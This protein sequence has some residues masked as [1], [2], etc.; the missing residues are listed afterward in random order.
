[1]KIRTELGIFLVLGFAILVLIPKANCNQFTFYMN[2]GES[3]GYSVERKKDEVVK[4]KFHTFNDP[5]QVR[6]VVSGYSGN[7]NP[8]PPPLLSEEKIFDS[9]SFTALVSS[10]FNFW[11]T[12]S[13]SH[14]GYIYIEITI[15]PLEEILTLGYNIYIIII[16]IACIAV[17]GIFLRKN[18]SMRN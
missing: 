17:V 8:L 6:L 10:E 5:F 12:N 4:W 15:N 11:F 7:G 9:G 3:K 16:L 1:M 2:S 13:D 14:G 18:Y